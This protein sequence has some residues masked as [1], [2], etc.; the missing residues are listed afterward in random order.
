[1]RLER[2]AGTVSPLPD[3]VAVLDHCEGQV[4]CG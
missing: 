4:A 1:M 2:L 3:V